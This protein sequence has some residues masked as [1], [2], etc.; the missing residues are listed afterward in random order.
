MGGQDPN[1]EV[2]FMTTALPCHH[3]AA[4]QALDLILTWGLL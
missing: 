4:Q 1:L 2:G 3:E